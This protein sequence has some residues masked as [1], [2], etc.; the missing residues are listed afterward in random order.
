MNML[1]KI[2]SLSALLFASN[3]IADDN[4]STNITFGIYTTDRPSTLIRQFTPVL[5]RMEERMES[6]L[7][8]NVTIDI[9]IT[10]T[11]NDAIQLLADGTFDFVRF[12]PVS[13]ITAK[14]L[15]EDIRIAALESIG[16]VGQDDVNN[17]VFYGILATRDNSNINSVEDVRGA[18][19]A[20]G[21]QSSTIGRYLAQ[22]FLMDNDI[23]EGDL[24]EYTYLERHDDVGR[25]VADG[26][27]DVGALKEN[28]FQALM[29]EGLPLREVARFPNVTKPWLVSPQVP[30]DVFKAMN[31]A[32]LSIIDPKILAKAKVDGFIDG[33]DSDY[34]IIREAITRNFLFF[35][36]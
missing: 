14:E 8:R 26:K 32:L 17:K 18:T 25:A 3:V 36:P 15:N 9:K 22:K 1:F 35:R 11:Y 13:Y 7:G 34:D 28:T 2:L 21:N 19:F 30:D 4:E 6:Y 23:L 29:A 31:I 24:A 16:S 27:Y 20:F 12:G 5:K 10:K 33:D